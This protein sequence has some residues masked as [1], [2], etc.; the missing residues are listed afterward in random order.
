MCFCD[1][2]YSV[3]DVSILDIDI[4]QL[5]SIATM[6]SAMVVPLIWFV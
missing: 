6:D 1:L 3:L 4:G 5:D 2:P